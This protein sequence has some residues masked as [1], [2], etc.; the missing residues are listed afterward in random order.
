MRIGIGASNWLS[1]IGAAG[2]TGG[3][4]ETA[5]A[6]VGEPGVSDAGVDETKTVGGGEARTHGAE[7]SAGAVIRGCAGTLNGERAPSGAAWATAD[8]SSGAIGLASVGTGEFA[9]ALATRELAGRTSR[10]MPKFEAGSAVSETVAVFEAA[11]V[12]VGILLDAGGF[13]G[14]GGPSAPER[15]GRAGVTGW[16]ER[17]TG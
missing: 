17:V 10:A 4:G 2:E 12:A 8:A 14:N 3:P 5:V 13:C 16:D 6:S 1:A 9:G 15:S 11:E 7:A